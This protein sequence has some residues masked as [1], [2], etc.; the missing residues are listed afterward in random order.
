MLGD[1]KSE[2]IEISVDPY[3]EQQKLAKEDDTKLSTPKVTSTGSTTTDEKD[4]TSLV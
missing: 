1:E 4:T 3:K 2:Q